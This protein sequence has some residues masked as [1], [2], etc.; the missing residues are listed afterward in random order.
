MFGFVVTVIF[1]LGFFMVL[2][3]CVFTELLQTSLI[4]LL[5][6]F[7]LPH[8]LDFQNSLIFFFASPP[9]SLTLLILFDCPHLIRLLYCQN[10]RIKRKDKEQ[11]LVHKFG[12]FKVILFTCYSS[13]FSNK[14]NKIPFLQK[15]YNQ[16]FR[17]SRCF[18]QKIS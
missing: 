5:D 15:V 7:S 9:F 8:L 18:F 4:K 17:H 13:Y 6:V 16:D 2:E 11:A 12:R 3:N 14:Q 10:A 1:F